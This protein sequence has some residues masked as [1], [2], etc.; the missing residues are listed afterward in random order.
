M[1]TKSVNINSVSKIVVNQVSL[2]LFKNS[3]LINE[4]GITTNPI[5]F[6]SAI[7]G[8]TT[9]HPDNPFLLYNDKDGIHDSVDA[10]SIQI[11]VLE[12]N[13]VDELV[14]ISNG[15][16]SQV[17][18]LGYSPVISSDSKNTVKVLVGIIEYTEV[19]TFSGVGNTETV[20]LVD[21]TN[22]TI[23]FGNG[24]NGIIPPNGDNIYVTYTP[25]TTTFGIEAR[26]DG[27]LYVQST[28]VDRHDRTVLLSSEIAVSTTQV[29]LHHIPII[30]TS[31][32]QGI[33]LKT[34]P[35]RLGINYFTGGSYNSTTGV[36]TLG[37]A[38]PG[39]TTDVLVDYK[40]TI[41]AYP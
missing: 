16:A 41:T 9:N 36:V 5:I 22:G 4:I 14:G 12:M 15:T 8:Q 23:T 25:G 40:Y 30:T 10:K 34:D 2:Q 19:F 28:D 24:V 3:D 37:T 29:Q 17:F 32:I 35:N 21:Y 20:Y 1:S 7:A 13:I 27:W 38:L 6:S 18:S 11:E 31:G 26:D 33:Y 39:G